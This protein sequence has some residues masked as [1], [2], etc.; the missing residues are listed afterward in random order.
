MKSI[1]VIVTFVILKMFIGIAAA[2][3]AAAYI[4]KQTV[5]SAAGYAFDEIIINDQG[6]FFDENDLYTRGVLYEPHFFEIN[7][8]DY[9]IGNDPQYHWDRTNND[10]HVNELPHQ[11][12][13][14]WSTILDGNDKQVVQIE[15][16]HC[17][18]A[19]KRGNEPLD[20]RLMSSTSVHFAS[21]VSLGSP[22]TIE[23]NTLYGGMINFQ[24]TG[25]DWIGCTVDSMNVSAKGDLVQFQELT[26]SPT[27]GELFNEDCEPSQNRPPD[28]AGYYYSIVKCSDY[29][30]EIARKFQD[31]RAEQ[32]N[33]D[34]SIYPQTGI[35]SPCTAT[36]GWNDYVVGGV[37]LRGEFLSQV[38]KINRTT[39]EGQI[40][41]NNS[42]IHTIGGSC[43]I[44]D[45]TLVTIGGFASCPSFTELLTPVSEK[46]TTVLVDETRGPPVGGGCLAYI[47]NE[48]STQQGTVLKYP[49]NQKYSAPYGFPDSVTDYTCSPTYILDLNTTNLTM[50]PNEE[51]FNCAAFSTSYISGNALF[52][53][54]GLSPEGKTLDSVIFHD[55]GN[56]S[57]ATITSELLGNMYIERI[58]PVIVVFENWLGNPVVEIY[59]GGAMEKQSGFQCKYQETWYAEGRTLVILENGYDDVGGGSYDSPGFGIMASI[60]GVVLAI[61]VVLSR[62][63]NESEA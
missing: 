62:R 43:I 34:E 2:N 44:V 16:D 31:R 9:I 23:R 19:F 11:L 28:D 27:Q 39:G 54:G 13:S 61:A 21:S 37:N 51:V 18:S 60:G 40:V 29:G 10:G 7:G 25:G 63:H 58:N 42:Q 12:I 30:T 1:K 5:W 48:Y 47:T 4:A 38:T 14:K 17:K 46:L 8:N 22:S 32:A 50:L 52:R 41:S 53:F 59:C 24:Y 3:P 49:F 56:I 15:D 36:D 45:N 6:E 55:L 20:E 35:L 57:S 33:F 26:L